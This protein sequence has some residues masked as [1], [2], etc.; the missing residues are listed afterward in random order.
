MVEGSVFGAESLSRMGTRGL[1]VKNNVSEKDQVPPVSSKS[2][3]TIVLEPPRR[4]TFMSSLR[5]H[6]SCSHGG[7]VIKH[8]LFAKNYCVEILSQRSLLYKNHQ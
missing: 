1:G 8:F 5:S 2:L 3:A 7:R 6:Y 4:K